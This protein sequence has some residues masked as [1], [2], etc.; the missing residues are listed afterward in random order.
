MFHG[1]LPRRVPTFIRNMS[2]VEEYER[3]SL[4][5]CHTVLLC[6][7]IRMLLSLVFMHMESRWRHVSVSCSGQRLWS[8]G[9]ELDGPND[10]FYI[11]S[12][13]LIIL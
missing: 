10:V 3:S 5:I 12:H 4:C 7:V 11:I 2:L 8:G 6:L 1:G 9:M 13:V